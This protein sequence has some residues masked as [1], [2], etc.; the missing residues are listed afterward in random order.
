MHRR[1]S[2]GAGVGH[3]KHDLPTKSYTCNFLQLLLEPIF[4]NYSI[5]IRNQRI[6]IV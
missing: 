6:R 3:R 2:K 1:G 4:Y 5:E